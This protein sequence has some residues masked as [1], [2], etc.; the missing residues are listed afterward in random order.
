MPGYKKPLDQDALTATKKCK[1]RLYVSNGFRADGKPNRSTKTIGPCSAAQ[2]DKLLQE[3]Y[4]EFSKRP[5]R[6]S[7]KITFKQFIPIWLDRHVSKL[8]PNTLL[9]QK[10]AVEVRLQPYFGDMK[11]NKI[12]TEHVIGFLDDLKNNGDR[13]DGREGTISQ[14]SI[15]DLFRLL[16]S[17]F[18]RAKEWNYI[19]SNPCDDVPRDKRPK[20]NY[21]SKAIFEE[22]ELRIFLTELFKLKPIPRNIKYQLFFYLSLIDGC[23][24][25][26]HYALTWKDIDFDAKTIIIS[27]DVYSKDRKTYIKNNTKNG[28]SRTVFIDDLCV[29]LLKKHREN[30]AKYLKEKQLENKEQ[31]IFIKRIRADGKITDVELPTRSGF[32]HWLSAFLKRIGLKHIDVHGFRRMAASYSLNNQVPLTTVQQM[33]G[34]QSLST[35]MIYLRSLLADRQR[36]AQALSNTYQQ[37]MQPESSATTATDADGSNKE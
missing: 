31:Y 27:K 22:E 20:A 26:E 16:R 8:S 37:L 25:G 36:S 29:E 14:G 28:V 21:Q 19:S 18:N 2:A 23:R 32:H 17:M 3:F 10:N 30:Q 5:P 7:N 34:H 4:L 9:G 13:L 11:L 24:S 12:T 6:E 35:T 33:L 1:W 15:H